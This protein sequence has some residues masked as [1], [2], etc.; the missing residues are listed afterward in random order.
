MDITVS[1]SRDFPDRDRVFAAL[2]AFK[3]EYP[4]D[5]MFAGGT[6][7]VDRFAEEW[8]LLHQVPCTVVPAQWDT[9]GKRA[10]HMRNIRMLEQS[11][12]LLAIF[13][14]LTA[15]TKH[16]VT[17]AFRMGLTVYRPVFDETGAVV[18]F[19]VAIAGAGIKYALT[20]ITG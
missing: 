14:V 11:D 10:G 9:F 20:N 4:F 8:A 12:A 17:H 2:D 1:G 18:R 6:R 13:D 15:G 16:A 5:R 3:A 7:G 19:A